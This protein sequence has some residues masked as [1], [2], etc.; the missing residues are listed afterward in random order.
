MKTT[1]A[2]QKVNDFPLYRELRKIGKME[3]ALYGSAHPSQ[4]TYV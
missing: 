4:V 1:I 2:V 3:G